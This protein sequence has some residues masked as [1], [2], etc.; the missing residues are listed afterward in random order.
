LDVVVGRHAI[1]EHPIGNADVLSEP[2]EPKLVALLSDAAIRAAELE[3]TA[4]INKVL[5]LIQIAHF[6]ET[7]QKL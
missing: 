6:N 2:T 5:C 3:I 4:I 1:S 7:N